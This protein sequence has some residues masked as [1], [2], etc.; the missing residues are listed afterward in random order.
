VTR[1]SPPDTWKLST[2]LP[3]LSRRV[4]MHTAAVTHVHPRSLHTQPNRVNDRRRVDVGRGRCAQYHA[5]RERMCTHRTHTDT[6][7]GDTGLHRCVEDRLQS[8]LTEVCG[9][10]LR[11]VDGA[12]RQSVHVSRL[13]CPPPRAVPLRSRRIGKCGEEGVGREVGGRGHTSGEA[14]GTTAVHSLRR[15]VRGTERPIEEM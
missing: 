11:G 12:G 8:R 13:P 5:A 2:A 15:N 10:R 14:R 4:R 7:A 9:C 1:A 3:R 6:M